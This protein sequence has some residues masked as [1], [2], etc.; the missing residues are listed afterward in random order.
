MGIRERLINVFRDV[1][2]NEVLEVSDSTSARD[3]TGWDSLTHVT[4]LVAIENEFGVKFN[5]NEVRSFQNVGGILK[6]L[7]KK[8]KR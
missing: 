2:D 5:L 8:A 6:L 4:L 3:I 1:F 7:E